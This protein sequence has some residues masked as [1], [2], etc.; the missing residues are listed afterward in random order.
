MISLIAAKSKEGKLLYFVCQKDIF[1]RTFK[2][3]F[4]SDSCESLSFGRKQY[5]LI[6]IPVTSDFKNSNPFILKKLHQF[7]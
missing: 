3:L 7:K 5:D 4:N 2:W 6:A 1:K